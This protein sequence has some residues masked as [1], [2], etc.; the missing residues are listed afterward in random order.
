MART[1]REIL[2]IIAGGETI[3]INGT[4]YHRGN[5][6]KV[7]SEADLALG[8]ARKETEA[9]VSVRNQIM[10]LEAE[11]KKLEASKAARAK[12]EKSSDPVQETKSESQPKGGVITGD[13]TSEPKTDHKAEPK[14]EAKSDAKK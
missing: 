1:R 2:D 11:L 7:P 4:D 12:E 6:H 3:N 10:Q 13:K 14:A 5:A 9:E 8:D